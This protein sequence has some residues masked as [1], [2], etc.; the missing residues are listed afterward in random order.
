[1]Y[2]RS[3]A[4]MSLAVLATSACADVQGDILTVRPVVDLGVEPDLPDQGRPM[5][6]RCTPRH[7]GDAMSCQSSAVWKASASFDCRSRGER[8]DGMTPIDPC[9]PDRYRA[10][11][12]FCCP[13]GGPTPV[14]TL[15]AMTR[16]KEPTL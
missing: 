4:L 13:A 14:R 2:M 1:M 12:Y 7:Q 11:A 8:A 9:G 3:F 6:P 15:G 10:I 16:G 5:P